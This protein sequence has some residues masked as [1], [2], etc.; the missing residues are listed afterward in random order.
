M[1]TYVLCTQLK[2][3]ERQNENQM[4]AVLQ[5]SL[6]FTNFTISSHPSLQNEFQ[7]KKSKE[8]STPDTKVDTVRP[9]TIQLSGISLSLKTNTID[10]ENSCYTTSSEESDIEECPLT[11]P[12]PPQNIKFVPP[13]SQLL[14]PLYPSVCKNTIFTPESIHRDTILLI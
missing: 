2:T 4:N 5:K 13:P 12:P 11:S 8:K 3:K 7:K 14:P 6:S 10:I 1:L 9:T